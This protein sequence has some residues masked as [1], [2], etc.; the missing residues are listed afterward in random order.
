MRQDENK[1]AMRMEIHRIAFFET[2]YARTFLTAS[3]IALS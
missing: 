3:A 2:A 1:K